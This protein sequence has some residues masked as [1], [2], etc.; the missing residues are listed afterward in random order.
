[1]IKVLL[2]SHGG[3]AKGMLEAAE[4]ILGQQEQVEAL[5][6]Y[7]GTSADDYVEKLEELI[8][9]W[10]NAEDVL[11]L[12]DL[13]GGTPANSGAL[14]SLKK[15]VTCLA[16]CNLPLVLEVLSSRKF[17]DMAEL[18]VSAMELGRE[19]LHNLSEELSR[20]EEEI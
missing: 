19:S 11:I 16:G 15:G 18:T 12:A 5:G 1:M 20:K 6:L 13:P 10:G 17:L 9:A 4:M 14:L 3:F 2:V 8:E 7:P